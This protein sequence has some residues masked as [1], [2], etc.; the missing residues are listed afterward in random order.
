[1][2]QTLINLRRMDLGF[3]PAGLISIY[4]RPGWGA[5]PGGPD[6]AI[7][8]QELRQRLES[9]PGVR[10]VGAAKGLPLTAFRQMFDVGV[11]TD[12]TPAG[13][14]PITATPWI[15]VPGYFEAMRLPLEQGRYFHP[16]DDVKRRDVAI[17][18]RLLAQKAFGAQDPIG[19]HVTLSSGAPARAVV[20]GVVADVITSPETPAK[21]TIYLTR[22]NTAARLSINLAIRTDDEPTMIVPRLRDAIVAVEPNVASSTS[23]R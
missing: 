19:R 13:E 17:I 21:E 18:S 1:M 4:L 10:T 5:G 22:S 6:M 16:E 3:E 9:V 2:A 23:A 12:A 14:P 20:V 15:V 11:T 8:Y 7:Y